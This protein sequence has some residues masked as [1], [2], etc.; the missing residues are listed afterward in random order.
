MYLKVG[1]SCWSDCKRKGV[2]KTA[3]LSV[4]LQGGPCGWDTEMGGK[5]GSLGSDNAGP[6]KSQ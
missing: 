2:E 6:C 4:Q 5:Q 1:P 3:C